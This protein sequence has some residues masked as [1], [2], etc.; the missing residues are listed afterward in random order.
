MFPYYISRD[1]LSPWLHDVSCALWH[2][3][4]TTELNINYSATKLHFHFYIFPTAFVFSTVLL[5]WFNSFCPHKKSV[6]SKELAKT[7]IDRSG[8][9][10]QRTCLNFFT[11]ISHKL[12][13]LF[14]SRQTLTEVAKVCNLVFSQKH[15]S[16]VYFWLRI[17]FDRALKISLR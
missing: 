16:L 1:H 2:H 17:W 15:R 5:N 9:R 6:I 13:Y 10:S 3:F 14:K 8:V 11:C 4:Q 12:Q 7:I